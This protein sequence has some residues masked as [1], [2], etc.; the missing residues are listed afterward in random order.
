MSGEH[1]LTL[2]VILHRFVQCEESEKQ[3]AEIDEDL[4]QHSVRGSVSVRG[5]W[6]LNSYF[7]LLNPVLTKKKTVAS[8]IY[9]NLFAGL[10]R[11]EYAAVAGLYAGVAGAL[12]DDF[13]LVHPGARRDFEYS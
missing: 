5:S 9:E 8:A 3:G 6:T 7:L 4:L 13:L 1:F 12:V 2:V 11:A 10:G